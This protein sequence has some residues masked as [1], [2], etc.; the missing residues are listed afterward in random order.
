MRWLVYNFMTS[1]FAVETVVRY[2]GSAADIRWHISVALPVKLCVRWICSKSVQQNALLIARD[3]FSYL[4]GKFF[5]YLLIHMI[6]TRFLTFELRMGT[7]PHLCV[8]YK[9]FLIRVSSC[10]Q[11]KKADHDVLVT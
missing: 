4:G 6:V 9:N 11:F 8:F 5:I 10:V 1:V 7:I 3:D 2:F